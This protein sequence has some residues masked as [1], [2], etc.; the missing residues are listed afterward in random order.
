MARAIPTP[1]GVAIGVIAGTRDHTVRLD[2]TRLPG[3]SARAEVPY[4]H[5]FIMAHRDVQDR[6][7]RFLGT[8][9]FEAG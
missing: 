6:V 3:E 4:M 5:S 1:P 2:E 8:G 9:R 7:I